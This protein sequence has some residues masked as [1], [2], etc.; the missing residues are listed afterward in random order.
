MTIKAVVF[1]AYGTLYDVQSVASVTDAA[2]PGYGEI[3][4]QIWRLKQ[5]EYTWLRSL[6]QRYED[7]SV[8][9]RESLTYTLKVLGLKADADIFDRIMDKYVHLDLYP[10]AREAL[11]GL[12]GR[13]LAILSNGSPDMLNALVRNTAL[14]KVLAA[15]ISIDSKRLFKP[16]PEV[17]TLIESGI[18]V[19]PSEVLFVSSNPFDVCGAKAFGLNVAWIER[20]TPDAMALECRRNDLVRPLTMFKAIRM[21]MDQLGFEP[22]YRIAG[23]SGLPKLLSAC[24]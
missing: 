23:L 2:F 10:D 24:A 4:S 16:S 18:G 9:T 7:F 3:I 1:D 14:D 20:V 6:M 17:Y 19:K 12:N 11:A 21:Q 8:I 13:K 22:D 15:T 5:L